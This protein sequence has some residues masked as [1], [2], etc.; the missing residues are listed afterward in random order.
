MQ[1][2]SIEFK[3][4][5]WCVYVQGGECLTRKIKLVLLNSKTGRNFI[6][7]DFRQSSMGE[8]C[9]GVV[10]LNTLTTW[11]SPERFLL[12]KQTTLISSEIST[13]EKLPIPPKPVKRFRRD[14]TSDQA[15]QTYI[16]IHDFFVVFFQ[17][18]FKMQSLHFE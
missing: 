17:F 8:G 4:I 14:E 7:R 18:F 16:C 9:E 5:Y 15:I 6:E 1:D 2:I 12:K 13:D 10:Y 11:Y 3:N